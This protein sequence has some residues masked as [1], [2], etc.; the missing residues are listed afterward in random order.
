MPLTETT[1]KTLSLRCD[2]EGRVL[3]IH[4]QALNT[5]TDETGDIVSRT[6]GPALPVDMAGFVSV[7][8]TND[9]A[10][11]LAALPNSL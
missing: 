10:T 11:L 8:H 6:A 9:Q 1:T 2:A 3:T 5:T 7:L 4:V